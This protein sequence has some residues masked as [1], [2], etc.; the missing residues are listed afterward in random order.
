MVINIKLPDN[1]RLN[2]T[3]NVKQLKGQEH[4][5][6]EIPARIAESCQILPDLNEST[7]NVS[8]FNHIDT[9]TND[10]MK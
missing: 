7:A 3:E 8:I 4:S 1:A 6:N 10:K 9:N 5:V 2:Y